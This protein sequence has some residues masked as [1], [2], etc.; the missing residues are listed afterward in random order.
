MISGSALAAHRN[1]ARAVNRGSG[2]RTHSIRKFASASSIRIW[3]AATSGDLIAW[4]ASRYS[5]LALIIV[6][7]QFPRKHVSWHGPCVCKRCAGAQG[8]SA[9]GRARLWDETLLPV[10]RQFAY[11]PF[12]HA[13]DLSM[14]QRALDLFGSI[15]ADA[16]YADLCRIKP[17]ALAALSRASAGF[18]IVMCCPEMC[19]ECCRRRV[20][21]AARLFILEVPLNV[22]SIVPI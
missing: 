13:E 10:E 3:E 1:T 14:Q 21:I 4:D 18:R 12:Q 17:Q 6:L 11:L 8:G 19:I 20:S 22:T 16:A 2:N 15:A 9:H 7:D 5:L